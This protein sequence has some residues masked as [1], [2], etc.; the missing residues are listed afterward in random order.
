MKFRKFSLVMFILV[1]VVVLAACGGKDDEKDSAVNLSQSLSGTMEGVGTITMAYPEGWVGKAGE[2]GSLAIA[3]SQATM[4]KMDSSGPDNIAKGEAAA[5]AMVM[6]V[7]AYEFFDW[8]TDP[9]PADATGYLNMLA[10]ETT[11]ANIG[12]AET[13]EVGGRQAAMASGTMTEGDST[14]GAIIV[15]VK[16]DEGMGLIIFITHPDEVNDYKDTAKAMAGKLEF[17]AAAT[18]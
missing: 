7:M 6:P 4:D 17:A 14:Q 16:F 9:S 1:L 5:V 15:A 8:G 2:D 18:E 10:G 11:E 3:N 12:E 13:F